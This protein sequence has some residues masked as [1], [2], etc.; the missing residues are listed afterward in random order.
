MLIFSHGLGG[1]RNAY[2]HICGSLASHGLV[3]AAVDHRDGSA[4]ISFIREKVGSQ[5]KPVDYMKLPHQTSPEVEEKRLMQLKIRC[6]EMGLVHDSLL[7]LDG[8]DNV[9]NYSATNSSEDRLTDFAG[10]LDIHTPGKIAWCGHSF[11][12][13]TV[14]QFVK[15]VF[16]SGS[17]LYSP[18]SSMPISQQITASSP[19]SLLDLWAMPLLFSSTASLWSKPLPAYSAVDGAGS[20]PL[21]ILSEAFF[22]WKAN[23]REI[24]HAVS[25]RSGVHSTIQPN[26]FYP[27]ASAHLSQSDFGPLFPWL[28]KKA[29]KADEPDRTLRLNVRAILET[30][31]RRGISIA[32]TSELDREIKDT[33]G[34][35]ETKDLETNTQFPL[36]QDHKIL[37]P[38]G[39]IR[40]WI[41][42]DPSTSD[43]QALISGNATKKVTKRQLNGYAK[44]PKDPSEAVIQG[45]VSNGQG[46]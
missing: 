25:P 33:V 37:D 27:V 2:S 28:T 39:S 19:V 29:L 13:A 44:E 16:Y 32:D 8:G 41:A 7:R 36:G 11:G 22:K 34:A 46:A 15:S 18:P 3:V 45:A 43:G 42:V 17:T 5:G 4:P 35:A 24:V 9:S 21:A 30:L 40:G 12:A 6:W 14:V 10:Q 20:P 26:I 1:T 38:E 23:F 31:R